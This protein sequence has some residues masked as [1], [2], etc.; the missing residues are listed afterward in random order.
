MQNRYLQAD[1][2]ARLG[3][4][5]LGTALAL[6]LTLGL[7]AARVEASQYCYGC[8]FNGTQEVPPNGSPAIGGGQFIIDTD[9]NTVKYH[10]SYGGL[11]GAETAAHFHGPADPGVNAGV[12]T[13][14]LYTSPSPRD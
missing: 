8:V 4:K 5:L 6:G 12:M 3:R 10:L 1:G 7:N 13:C 2:S 14:L 9:A 11:T